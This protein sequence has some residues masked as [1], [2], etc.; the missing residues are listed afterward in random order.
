MKKNEDCNIFPNKK[1][2]FVLE[3]AIF[4]KKAKK[5]MTTGIK[6]Q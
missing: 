2:R 4:T 5:D 3:I 1:K 6:F